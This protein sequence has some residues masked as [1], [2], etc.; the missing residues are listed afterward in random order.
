MIRNRRSGSASTLVPT[1]PNTA[2]QLVESSRFSQRLARWLIVG[3]FVAIAAMLFLP[4]QQTSRAAGQVIAYSPQERQQDILAPIK[5][6]ISRVMPGLQDGVEVKEGQVLMVLEPFSPDEVQQLKNQVNNLKAKLDLEEQS[7]VFFEQNILTFTEVGKSAVSAAEQM[8][9][10]ARAKLE[11][12][13]NEVLG[14]ETK[15]WQAEQNFERQ[16]RLF[17]QGIRAAK[18]I[19]KLKAERD[20]ATSGLDALFELIKSLEQDVATKE[21]QVAEKRFEAQT[22]V[23]ESETKML[24]SKGKVEEIRKLISEIE[25]K[26]GSLDRQ[27]IK[28]PRDGTIFRIPFQP[29]QA[30]KEGDSLM[31]FVPKTTQLAIELSVIGNDMPLVKLGQEVRLQF[32][33]WPAV[34]VAGWPSMSFGTFSGN[35]VQI[36]PT[37]N[38]KGQFRILVLPNEEKRI[39]SVTNPDPE[40]KNAELDQIW[41]EEERF[42]RQGVRANGWVILNKVSLGYE[43]WRQLNGFPVMLGEDEEKAEKGAKPPKIPK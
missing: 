19:E 42:L 2:L 38:G 16:N 40:I 30:V 31:T 8:L 29:N 9:E 22:K 23:A 5:G 24:A 41:P 27:E 14:Y 20:F 10:S 21:S 26:L 1:K 25:V 28:A 4:W 35:V 43:L 34:Q 37:D 33:G 17:K 15:V 7:V 6:V 39:V 13:R 3:L 12:K 36:D 11:S 32:E 18:D